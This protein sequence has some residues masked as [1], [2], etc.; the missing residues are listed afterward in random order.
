MA[1]KK[2]SKLENVG[3][4]SNFKHNQDFRYGSGKSQNCNIVFGFNG[5]GKTTLSNVVSLFS[6][7]S[8]LTEEEKKIIYDEIKNSDDSTIELEL[9]GN[10][11]AKYPSNNPHNKD[12]YVFNSNF[13]SSHVF[14]G[15]KGRIKKFSNVRGEIGSDETRAI[16]KK[17]E[18][19]TNE[20]DALEM[21]N[22]LL[23]KR[24]EEI[25][26]RRSASFNQTFLRGKLIPKQINEA[27]LPSDDVGIL[28][29]RI[30]ELTSDYKLSNKQEELNKD[31]Q[32][33]QN[34]NFSLIVLD[35]QKAEEL[36]SKNIQQLSKDILEKKIK[37]IQSLFLEDK[38]KQSVERWFRFGKEILEKTNEKDEKNCPICDTDISVNIESI[39]ANFEGYFNSD[40]ESFLSEISN[41]S[42]KI[43][44]LIVT[45]EENEKVV[46]SVLRIKLKYNNLFNELAVDT[47]N[48]SDAKL[49]LDD[50]KKIFK[51]KN[52][53]IQI[54]LAKPNK[55]EE[56]IN[57]LNSEIQKL[58]ISRQEILKI[59]QSKKLNPETIEREIKDAYKNII[60]A[61]FDQID[62]SGVLK[63]Y[64]DNA[65]RA[66]F[67]EKDRTEGLPFWRNKLIEEL[68]KIKA[69][70][71]SISG[72]L[73]KMGMDN[74]EI[75]INENNPDQNI[76]VRYKNSNAEKNHLRNCLSEGE[77]TA[78]AFAY[79]LSKFDNEVEK[80]RIKES[81]VLIDD[82]I[83]SLDENRLYTTAHLI[84]SKFE[85]VK[86]LI[87]LSHNFLF[88]KF[89]NSF[90]KS[91]EGANCLFLSD[92]E[93]SLLPE[94]LKN[95]ETPYFYMLR[96]ILDYLDESRQSELYHDAKKYL[97][98]FI[99]RVLETFLSFKFS[100]ILAKTV[101][102]RSPGLIEFNS[103]IDDTDMHDDDKKELKEK[104]SEING[105]ADAHSHGNV[106]HTQ[107]CF[108][109]SKDD[110]KVLAKNA[111]YII[112]KMDS[113]HKTSFVSA[114]Q[115]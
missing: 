67:I 44:S 6:K 42:E 17:I 23:D 18:E 43:S 52:D 36:L 56:I 65:V 101:R 25:K 103:S 78:L 99:R 70:S 46:E 75:D 38:Y 59:L 26:K 90:Y 60:I 16:N 33:L 41:F 63:K 92:E 109:I 57:L 34:S 29:S 73:S 111:I 88:L 97:P 53:N 95:F 3:K 79:F 82:P 74:F 35:F 40:Y 55:I 84:Q 86:Q 24:Y 14:D 113:L 19:L 107:E 115:K 15:K 39:L 4:F 47:I 91:G 114:L 104:I 12:F 11:K 9:Q 27:I 50:L 20:K 106:H 62:E 22:A 31:T 93:I 45:I 71:K 80:D 30:T 66:S 108:Y 81:V 54:T 64:K 37:E 1:I 89:F 87:V 94:E 105:I 28:E 32:E 96:H 85:E 100:K 102:S 7:N 98:N 2:L 83:S 8:F 51:L 69:E 5:S 68:V 21:E 61:E 112:E 77:K 49:C 110:L 72:Y 76:V 13:V 10:S 48:F 58:S